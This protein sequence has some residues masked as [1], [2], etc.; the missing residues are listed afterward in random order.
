MLST[1]KT[2]VYSVKWL[3]RSLAITEDNRN[4]FL[5]EQ[6]NIE[7]RSTNILKIFYLI[8]NYSQQKLD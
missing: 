1:V 5:S 2:Y 7:V 8:L 4:P 6:H 3:D